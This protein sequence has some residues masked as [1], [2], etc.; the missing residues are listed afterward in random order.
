MKT[1]LT[2]LAVL[3]V[4]QTEPKW[5]LKKEGDG[6]KVFV[7]D[8]ES[9][10]FKQFKVEAEVAATP[11]EIVDAVTDLENNYK[12]FYGVEKG[13]VI[14]SYTKY[15]YLFKQVVAV[16]F[17]FQ[18][19]QVVQLCTV[20]ELD[21]GVIRID[22]KHNNKA[23]PADDDYVRMPFAVGYWILTPKGD[24]TEI[25][26]SFLADPGGNIPAWLANQFIVDNPFKTIKALREFL[27]D[28]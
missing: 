1:V 22:L 12:W 10:N 13:E 19:R 3:S 24:K 9:S 18:D 25:E 11:R 14:E 6:I 8:A 5:E 2:L 15:N 7:A 20:T 27:K 4:L 23:I 21:E 17:P 28:A 16:P 26:Y